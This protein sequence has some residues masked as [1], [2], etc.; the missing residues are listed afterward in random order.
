MSTRTYRP[1]GEIFDYTICEETVELKVVRCEHASCEG[2]FFNRDGPCENKEEM[3]REQTGSC[4]SV[5]RGDNAS[6][7]FKVAE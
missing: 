4:S 2:C 3:S 7:L 6:V 1:I 5:L